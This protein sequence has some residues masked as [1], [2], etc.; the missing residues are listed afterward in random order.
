MV[1]DY[2]AVAQLYEVPTFKPYSTLSQLFYINK[3]LL[4]ALKAEDVA[5]VA[6]REVRAGRSVVIGMSDTLECVLRDY[7]GASIGDDVKGDFSTILLRLLDKTLRNPKDP[8]M[9]LSNMVDTPEEIQS[10]LSEILT[11]AEQIKNGIENSVFHLPMSPIDVTR[12]LITQEEFTDNQGIKRNIR[13]EECTGRA[14]Q[15]EYMS[16]EG[17]DEYVNAT[18][19]SRKKRHSNHIYNDF[20]NNKIDVVLINA[21]GAIGASAHAVVTA[22]VP[23]EKVRQRKMLI[24]QSDLDVNIDLQK[25]GRINRIGQV[26]ELPPLYEYIIT[27]IPSEKRLNMMLRAK[28]RSLSANTTANQDQERCQTDFVDITNKY[29]NQVAQEYLKANQELASVLGL[30]SQSTASQ[31]LARLA[32]LGVAAQQEIIEEIVSSYLNLEQELRRINQWDLECEFRDFEAQFVRDE[33]FTSQVDEYVLGGASMLSTFRCRHRTYP[34]EAKTLRLSIERA[35]EAYGEKPIESVQLN[36]EIAAY[37]AAECEKIRIKYKKRR[38]NLTECLKSDLENFNCADID[39]IVCMAQT[40]AKSCDRYFTTRFSTQQIDKLKSY[41]SEYQDLIDRESREFIAKA[42][43]RKQLLG[44]LSKAVIGQGLYNVISLMPVDDKVERVIAVLKEIRFGKQA[45]QRFLPSKVQFVFALSA[46]NK[47]LVL[48]L[49]DKGQN[50]NYERLVRLLS[51]RKWKFDTAEWNREIA[52]YNNR[53]IERKIITG[54]ILGAFSH[55]LIGKVKP[56]FISFTLAPDENGKK[57]IERG[58][59]LPISCDNMEKLTKAVGLPLSEG[60]KYANT[61]DR[62]FQISGVG[63]DFSVSPTRKY[64]ENGLYFY[65]GINEK[66]SKKFEADSRFDSIREYFKQ[67]PNQK[68]MRYA[69]ARLSGQSTEFMVIMTLLASL[70]A[71]IMIPREYIT[72]GEMK[73]YASPRQQIENSNWPKLDWRNSQALPPVARQVQMRIAAPIAKDGNVMYVDEFSP[74]ILLCQ[75]TLAY[76]GRSFTDSAVTGKIRALYFDWLEYTKS[77]LQQMDYHWSSIAC[78]VSRDIHRVLVGSSQ[79]SVIRFDDCIY[80][81]LQDEVNKYRLSTVGEILKNYRKTMLF[82][83]PPIEEAEAFLDSCLYDPR[84]TKIR[85]SLENYING[86]SEMIK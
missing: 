24:V 86:K 63:I 2:M 82:M 42:G 4:L 55:E 20:Q 30:K 19:C 9:T 18:V 67:T 5:K 39:E 62:V 74:E 32:M 11:Y 33:L 56:R 43:Q 83:S 48:N 75:R 40:P 81:I 13:F 80:E 45:E 34:Y 71:T 65:V 64:G 37:Y 49:S 61:P 79:N 46:V 57:H 25:R 15:L 10:K 3:I 50:S 16:P 8:S 26:R 53:I 28:L 12:R 72:V 77:D 27:A 51:T 31:L 68:L 23:V 41:S 14:R 70:Q 17:D 38:D 7:V 52:K 58:L 54:N 73:E 29:G 60:L 76:Q 36:A 78:K 21:C 85:Q 22:E 69:T 44:I 66:D 6:V 1:R 59:L 47:E 84:L 35:K